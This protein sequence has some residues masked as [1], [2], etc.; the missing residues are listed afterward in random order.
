MSFGK[1]IAVDG[2]AACI[3]TGI[4]VYLGY[5]LGDYQIVA[6]FLSRFRHIAFVVLAIAAGFII[7]RV[8]VYQME[9]RKD[10]EAAAQDED[11]DQNQDR[12]W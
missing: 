7:Y 4:F 3:T 2:S 9:A 5:T 11:E 6:P 10:A 1:F 12:T 8:V